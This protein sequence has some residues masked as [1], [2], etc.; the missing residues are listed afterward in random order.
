MGIV[1]MKSRQQF[2]I[3][4]FSFI[5]V[6]VFVIGALLGLVLNAKKTFEVH[7]MAY[8]KHA[9][10]A[11]AS[12]LESEQMV[13]NLE[14]VVV[15]YPMEIK[16]MDKG[17]VVF[18]TLRLDN[19]QVLQDVLNKRVVAYESSGI[20]DRNGHEILVWYSLYHLP[21]QDFF[22]QLVQTQ[23]WIIAGAFVLM[24]FMLTII[25]YFVLRPLLKMKKT[26]LYVKQ[27]RFD[28]M[29]EADDD[30][31]AELTEFASTTGKAIQQVSKKN[32]E[33]EVLL[34]QQKQKLENELLF[35]RVLIHEL[36]TPVYQTLI[37]NQYKTK[38]ES[39]QQ[40][41]S[42]SQYNEQ[43]MDLILEEINQII[44]LIEKNKQEN[45]VSQSFDLVE[46]TRK[47]I[48]LVSQSIKE[49]HLMIDFV[50]PEQ[51]IVCH[52]EM[53]V[54]MLLHNLISNMVLYA[55]NESTIEI[56]IDFEDQQVIMTFVNES[57]LHNIER[58]NQSKNSIQLIDATN[59][60]STGQGL[61]FIENLVNMMHG[62][63]QRE[64]Q[65]QKVVSRITFG[66]SDE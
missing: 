15:Q 14:Q 55:L 18:K 27:N 44:R 48:Q 43:R 10:A 49:K 42:L 2:L 30:L 12:A 59:P 32:T 57:D 4:V 61:I 40:V 34:N 46:T 58:L 56:D 11:L 29:V 1:G 31:N 5:L 16:V 63:Y 25:Q 66:I 33:L 50:V 21:S 19:S 38:H 17:E 41:L 51:L 52:Q 36:K 26:L 24:L 9:Q 23:T 47:S 7:E 8:I 53:V 3:I 6:Y 37:E 28:S 45:V 65:G 64:I 62:H 22:F 39:N 13:E 60:Y 35:T 20:F 54:S